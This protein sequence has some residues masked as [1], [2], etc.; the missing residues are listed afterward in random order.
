MIEKK[1]RIREILPDRHRI[2]LAKSVHNSQ[3]CGSFFQ[4]ASYHEAKPIRPYL[5]RV[6]GQAA[7]G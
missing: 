4:T 2:G 1:R 6:D 3:K 5:G 7:Q